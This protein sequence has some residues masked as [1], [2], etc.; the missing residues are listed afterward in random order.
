M[1]PRGKE[2][3]MLSPGSTF[4]LAGGHSPQSP[5]ETLLSVSLM[6]F[7]VLSVHTKVSLGRF[8][9]VSATTLIYAH[10]SIVSSVI[11][12]LGSFLPGSV[13]S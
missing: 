13:T 5:W 6:S 3:I 2:W 1:V 4:S 7:F 10:L 9:F 8:Y 11:I 12:E